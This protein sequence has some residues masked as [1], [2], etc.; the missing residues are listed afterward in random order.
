MTPFTWYSIAIVALSVMAGMGLMGV[1]NRFWP[2][3]VCNLLPP[4]APDAPPCSRPHLEE[5]A[6]RKPPSPPARHVRPRL[7]SS[8]RDFDL[9][10]A[11]GDRTPLSS[12]GR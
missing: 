5:T 6:W 9:P 11:P 1:I 8:P 2:P 10:P 7:N 4:P 3:W 12:G